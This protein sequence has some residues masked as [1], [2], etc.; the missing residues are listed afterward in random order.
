LAR[1]QDGCGSSDASQRRRS[2][3]CCCACETLRSSSTTWDAGVNRQGLTQCGSPIRRLA[4]PQCARAGVGVRPQD[5]VQ[6]PGFSPPPLPFHSSLLP[7][8][9]QS[10]Y[11]SGNPRIAGTAQPVPQRVGNTP[12]ARISGMSTEGPLR[13]HRARNLRQAVN[14]GRSRF[15]LPLLWHRQFSNRDADIRSLRPRSRL[16]KRDDGVSFVQLEPRRIAIIG[17]G[18]G[19]IAKYCYRYLPAAR[20]DAVESDPSAIALRDVFLI[21]RDDSRFSVIQADGAAYLS[22]LQRNVDAVLVDVF[23]RNDIAASLAHSVFD[24]DARRRLMPRGMFVLNLAAGPATYRSHL[25]WIRDV[26]GEAVMPVPSDDSGNHVVFASKDRHFQPQW[27][28][29][30]FHARSLEFQFGL[31]FSTY[32]RQLKRCYEFEVGG[33][34]RVTS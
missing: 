16:Y 17:L 13:A 7:A 25:G 3:S 32:A 10:A 2:C 20:S 6:R 5:A 34:C 29:L 8:P 19:S 28:W 30:L 26:F 9:Q 18:G 11:E 22:G 1:A 31:E 15:A 12:S 33:V 27:K 24:E 21:P 23:D 4:T 14:P